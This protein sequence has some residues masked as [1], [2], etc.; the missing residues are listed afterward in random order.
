MGFSPAS[1]AKVFRLLLPPATFAGRRAADLM[2]LL[3]LRAL[4]FPKDFFMVVG[5]ETK[6]EL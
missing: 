2:A 3:I 6:R 1:G 4:G 5:E